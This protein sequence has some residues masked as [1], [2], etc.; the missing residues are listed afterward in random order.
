MPGTTT[1]QCVRNS[2]HCAKRPEFRSFRKRSEQRYPA[3]TLK[4]N[5]EPA[6]HSGKLDALR[7]GLTVS[8]PG[9]TIVYGGQ[10][11]I[12][13]RAWYLLCHQSIIIKIPWPWRDSE[14]LCF[15]ILVSYHDRVK[16]YLS[17]QESLSQPLHTSSIHLLEAAPTTITYATF[18]GYHVR[19]MNKGMH[20][21]AVLD[22]VAKL[23]TLSSTAQNLRAL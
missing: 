2:S 8:F 7:V 17:I 9:R 22:R 13:D 4:Y 15:R 10:A 3:N 16:L 12:K 23:T 20:A 18:W 5:K 14:G 21:C 6:C 11:D 1:K 19:Y